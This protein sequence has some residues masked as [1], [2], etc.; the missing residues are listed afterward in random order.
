M[1]ERLPSKRPWNMMALSFFYTFLYIG[2]KSTWLVC[3]NATNYYPKQSE[4]VPNYQCLWLLGHFWKKVSLNNSSRHP[5]TKFL[6]GESLKKAY[7]EQ[8]HVCVP[9]CFIQNKIFWIVDAFWL[10]SKCVF[11]AL[12]LAQKRHVRMIRCLQLDCKNL[13][14]N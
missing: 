7:I 14:T 4:S 11:I 5:P 1:K 13:H 6:F 3:E 8:L 12:W 10:V 2:S 9:K